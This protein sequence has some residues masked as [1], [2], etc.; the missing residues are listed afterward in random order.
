MNKQKTFDSTSVLPKNTG[1]GQSWNFTS[2]ATTTAVASTTFI[3]ASSTPS[4]SLFPGATMAEDDGTGQYNYWKTTASTY[5][6]L[7]FADNA[8]SAV[9]FTNSAIAAMWPVNFGYANTDTYAGTATVS[10]PGTVNGTLSLNGTGTG[11]V[12]L[13]GSI[14]LT[15]ILQLKSANTM[16]LILGTFPFSFS[17]DVVSTEYSYYHGTQ[18]FPVVTV[19]YEKQTVNTGSTPTITNSYYVNVNN[20]VLTGIT[21]MNFDAINY[22]VY[23]NPATE[24]VNINLT[25]DASEN[26]SVVV[27]NNLGQVV[28]SLDLGKGIEVKH[29]MNTSDLACGIYYVKT[30]IGERSNVKKLIIQ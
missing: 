18:K 21:D 13:P 24:L 22:N 17:V 16:K 10:L 11:T 12:T 5:E 15:N 7:G 20:N 28:R 27:M 29:Q 14:T 19:H 30:S 1:A 26:V 9:T 6:L 23:P 8:G 3:A 25:N 4:A 2:L